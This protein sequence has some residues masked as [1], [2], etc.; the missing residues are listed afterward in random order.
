M[1]SS[2]VRTITGP[3]LLGMRARYPGITLELVESPSAELPDQVAQGRV[4]IAIVTIDSPVRGLILQPLI[5]E[6]LFVLM[7]PNLKNLRE[8][9]TLRELAKL[10]II[11]PSP[12]NFIRTR[13]D[14]ALSQ[15]GFNYEVVAE[16]S[17]TSLLISAV[18]SGLGV[19]VLPLSTI[20]EEAAD[21]IYAKRITRPSLSRQLAIC[22][23]AAIPISVAGEK[24]RDMIADVVRKLVRAKVWKGAKDIANA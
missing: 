24:V 4:E 2:I 3:L 21:T 5:K 18:K 20:N 14:L 17:T 10:P 19:T 7:P 15:A 16:A 6:D 1:P 13:I 22:T 23:T 9:I 8:S 11:L 12:P